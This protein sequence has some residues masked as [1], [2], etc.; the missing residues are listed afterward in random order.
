LDTARTPNNPVLIVDDER[1]ALE[2]L[3]IALEFLGYD[4]VVCCGS[5]LEAREVLERQEI[6]AVLLDMVMPQLSGD[7]LLEEIRLMQ[8]DV[9]VIMVTALSD[10]DTAVRCMRKGAF[11]Y[12][13]KP[14]DTDRL[15]ASLAKALERHSLNRQLSILRR[16]ALEPAQGVPE[17]FAP[18]LTRD[19]GMLQLL[20]Y[21]EAVA[22]SL[23]PVLITGETGTGKELVA[24][25]LHEASGRSGSF[26]A[27]NVSGLDDQVFSDTLFGHKKG[28]FT[29]ADQT[30]LGL[31]EKAAGGTLFLDEIGD[32]DEA[33]QIRL[34]RLLQEREFYPL[35]SDRPVAS[36]A[37]ILVATHCN[38]QE[39]MD[40][41][42][43]RQDLFYRLKT[44]AVHLPPL[45][46][47]KTDI[48]L[49]LE[50]FLAVAAEEL[51]KPLPA[52]PRELV[53]LLHAYHFPGNVREL[54]AMVYD[55]VSVHSA[56]TLSLQ[57]F[58]TAVGQGEG[59]A[60]QPPETAQGLF[61]R[62]E[63]L[64]TLREAADALVDQAMQ[65]ARNNQRVAA[66]MLGITPSALNKR[67]KQREE[68][69][70]E[71]ASGSNQGE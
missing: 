65:R 9:P 28:A 33:S 61:E 12:L 27:V 18:I 51:R 71:A 13:T 41:G 16:N 40:R 42:D 20:G 57:S 46:Q 53:D 30:R 47:R 68:Q 38:L 15:A 70:Q 55:A 39:A 50:H 4:N 6:E 69:Q 43:F 67:L 52:W 17:A 11:D 29:G 26:V 25:G 14:V 34:L 56:Y 1:N 23:E 36:S 31:I 37:R 21:C 35:G 44:H 62:V 10:L 22:Q 58:R 5:P 7:A 54:R 59:A 64:P 8:P 2:S 63:R 49:L 19:P 24:R 32:L 3:S 66:G 48:P 60:P 45:R